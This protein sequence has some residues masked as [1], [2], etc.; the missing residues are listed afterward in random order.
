MRTRWF[1]CVYFLKEPGG[2]AGLT[3]LMYMSGRKV[4]Q[5]QA[6]LSGQRKKLNGVTRKSKIKIKIKFSKKLFSRFFR[7]I[8]DNLIEASKRPNAV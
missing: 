6:L 7:N 1:F 5:H 2:G 8:D 3:S 4:L